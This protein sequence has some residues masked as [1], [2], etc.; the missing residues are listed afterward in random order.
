MEKRI[1]IVCTDGTVEIFD[2]LEFTVATFGDSDVL[3]VIL[4]NTPTGEEL[5][6]KMIP[7]TRIT[8][9]NFDYGDE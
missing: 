4:E 6:V 8:E 3:F 5:P 2:G 9:I 7:V 1:S